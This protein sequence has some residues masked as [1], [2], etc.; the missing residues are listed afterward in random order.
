MDQ[1]SKMIGLTILLLALLVSAPA[2]A[3]DR[4]D[5][6]VLVI[7]AGIAGV[8]A[9]LEASGRGARVLVVDANSVGGGHAVKAGG[10]A[11]VGT[12]LQESRGYR[13][14]PDIAYRDLMAWGEDA[15][16]A[17]V[18]RYVDGSRSEV[19]DWLSGF[20][21]RFSFILDTPE[22]SVP[23]FH[24][25]GGSARNV[26]V[27][28]L[29]EAFRRPNI[30]FGWSTEAVALARRDGFL[31]VQ[32]R[33]LRSGTAHRVLVRAVILATGGYES[34]LSRVRATWPRDAVLPGKLYVG[35][36]EYALGTGLPLATSMGAA[37]TR[38]DHQAI[39]TAGLP[40]PADPGGPRALLTQNPAAIWVDA[41]GR[42]FVNERA[43][44]KLTD[45]AVLAHKPATYWLVFDEPGRRSLTIRGAVWLGDPDAGSVL[46][47]SPHMHRAD[48][49]GEL[50]AAAGLPPRALE[51][52]VARYNASVRA[53]ND[54]DYGRFTNARPDK[55]ARAIAEPPF[56]AIQLF[57]LSRKSMGGVQVDGRTRVLDGQGK[58]IPGLYAAGEVTGVA[59]INGSFGGEGTFLGPSVFMGRI[60]GRAA[61]EQLETRADGVVPGNAAGPPAVT[62]AGP[63]APAVTVAPE[64]LTVLVAAA[65]PG[66]WHFGQVHQ[67]VQARK[68]DCTGCHSA[69]WPTR[70]PVTGAEWQAALRSCATCH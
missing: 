46:A 40:D 62:P 47:R 28:M 6:D 25:A 9:A 22:H 69:E 1:S 51:Q 34:D 18:R 36:G 60:A 39:F 66:Y 16:P 42:R 65:R 64:S 49:L 56:H 3:D 30:G 23:R 61:A 4:A 7:G 52:A 48:S 21:V 70:T 33:E 54:G 10:F 27:P 67:T 24:F 14:T 57:P 43:P 26:V 32:L 5:A 68:L 44:S 20:G 59:G 58:A 13:D 12:P 31:E 63:G 50:A 55:L 2:H 41:S 8:S 38:L 53:G 35:S 11:L 17:W 19:H 29:S 15:D 37:L 45:A